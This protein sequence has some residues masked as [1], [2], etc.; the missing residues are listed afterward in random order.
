M[1]NALTD[2]TRVTQL[3]LD[4]LVTLSDDKITPSQKLLVSQKLDEIQTLLL[5]LL[6][7]TNFKDTS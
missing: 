7:D 3:F 5:T 4:G 1:T 6:K 2:L